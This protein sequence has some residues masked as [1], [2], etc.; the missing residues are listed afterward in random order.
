ML[1]AYKN[2]LDERRSFNVL[3]HNVIATMACN[4]L[5]AKMPVQYL[6]VIGKLLAA[7][8]N[9]QIPERLINTL[10]QHTAVYKS[11]NGCLDLSGSAGSQAAQAALLGMMDHS[12]PVTTLHDTTPA[13]TYRQS[14]NVS[15][16][17][18]MQ[19]C[20]PKPYDRRSPAHVNMPQGGLA[21]QHKYLAGDVTSVHPVMVATKNQHNEELQTTVTD[22][23]H[24]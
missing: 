1:S 23:H 6:T 18:V 21:R 14:S 3:D 20:V 7:S 5:V 17:S 11:G 4:H 15:L 2:C 13:D 22:S 24:L 9:F 19:T 16:Y 12:T 8:R 10:H